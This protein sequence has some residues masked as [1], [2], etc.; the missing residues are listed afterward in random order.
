MILALVIIVLGALLAAANWYSPF[1][2]SLTGKHSSMIPPIGGL[3]I[4]IG[5]FSLTG[6]IGWALLALLSDLGMIVLIVFLPCLISDIW[7]TAKINEIGD[8]IAFRNGHKTTLKL[9]KNSTATFTYST[10]DTQY[11]FSGKWAGIQNGY[12]IC[13]YIGT[14]KCKLIWR[15]NQLDSI[16]TLGASEPHVVDLNGLVF[17]AVKKNG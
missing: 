2:K 17:S 6:S 14:R 16:E 9:Y 15:Q 13:D 4:G 3:F 1:S 10:G 5:V 7:S 12:E 8:Y 11:G